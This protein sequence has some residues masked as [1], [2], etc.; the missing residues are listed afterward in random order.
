MAVKSPVAG[1]PKTYFELVKKFPLTHIHSEEHLDEAQEVIEQLLRQE[2]DRGAEEYLAA[3]T[4]LVEA[5]ENQHQPIPEVSEAELLRELMRSG[6]LSQ[7][8]L[9]KEVGIAQST[10]SAVLTG[11]RSLTKGQIRK[12]AS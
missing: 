12:L 1:L 6:G 2:L 11:T 10:I 4:D 5:Y 8:T 7:K 9:E 3:L